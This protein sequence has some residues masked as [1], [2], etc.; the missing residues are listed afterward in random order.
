[1]I[2]VGGIWVSPTEVEAT[3]NGHEAVLECAVVGVIDEQRLVRPEAYVILQPGRS[4]GV[5]L[6]V[7]L[8]EFVRA[9]LAHFKCP[10]DF[11]F[12]ETLPKTA[13]GKIQRFKLRA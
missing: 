5:E 10:R 9:R 2:K 11:H 12:V 4:A 13:T 1:M 7:E 8:R 6:E 3:I